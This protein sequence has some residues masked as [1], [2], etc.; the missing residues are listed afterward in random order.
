MQPKAEGVPREERMG[1]EAVPLKGAVAPAS[2]AQDGTRGTVEDGR[3]RPAAAT[4]A[5][6]VEA[7]IERA[8]GYLVAHQRDG[9]HWAGTLSSSALATAMSCVALHLAG[10]AGLGA[11][12]ERIRRGRRWLLQTQHEDGGWGD[13]VVDP[14]NV[15]A[16]SLALAA[17]VL[18][19]AEGDGDG[20]AGSP[21][22]GE[23]EALARARARLE[24]FGGFAAVGDPQRCTLSGPCRTVA[25]LAGL[26]DAR[27]MK[28]L[29][30]EVI[31]LPRRLRRTIST[32]FPAYLS[33][34]L[35]HSTLAPHPLN[36]LPTYGRARRAALAWLERAQGPNGSFEESAFLTSVIIT[37]MIG[38]GQRDLPW[39]RPAIEFVVSSQREDGGWPIDRDLETFDTDM[40][41]F[42]LQEAGLAVPH[43]EQVADWLLARQFDAPCF[44]TGAG[45]GGWAWAM[46]AG[47]P[48]AD[49][50]SYTIMA[51]R[52]LGVSAHA[53]AIE[54]GARWLEGMQNADGSWP[55]FVRN[56]KMPF[57]HDCP[58]ITG[59]V[60]SA[61][62]AAGW[63]EKHPRLLER[64]LAYLRRA[65]RADGSF[66]SIWFREATA[67]TASVLEALADCGL[68]QTPMAQRARTYLLGSQNEDGG[69]GG[70][71][72]QASTAEETAWALLALLRGHIE[73]AGGRASEDSLAPAI[74]A[75]VRRGVAWLVATQRANG[76][77]VPAPI[78]LYYSAMWYSDSYYAISLPLQALARARAV[79]GHGL[80]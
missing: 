77:W 39:L 25:A 18:T 56:S 24:Q 70:R 20:P 41:V 71:R 12:A 69:W 6:A 40:A 59:H 15:N 16:T 21:E 19:A 11:H 61:L 13:A 27:T 55:T 8:A 42:A 14:S 4:A 17:L 58:Y 57:D 66:G 78:G 49:D 52:R 33:L 65:Q 34:A 35:L 45:P 54:R 23:A 31:L 74:R 2:G 10:R 47:W 37:G 50:T 9:N 26:M 62:Q 79:V 5:T 43:A 80:G 28:R 46:P 73:D 68:A 64:A 63:L 1:R 53:P 36:R 60:L 29:R 7:A 44:P 75:A 30:P 67:G 76:T 22:E 51:L 48:D 38:A 3:S 32:T 72:G